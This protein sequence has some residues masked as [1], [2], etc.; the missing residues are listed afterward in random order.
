MTDKYLHIVCLDTPYPADYGGAIDIFYTLKWLSKLGIKIHLH[1]FEYGRGRQPELER[2]CQWVHYYPRKSGLK[3]ISLRLPYIVSSRAEPDLLNNLKKDK[4]PVLLEGIHTSYFLH[5]G[6]LTQRKVIL[7]LQNVE[8]KYYRELRRT[9]RSAINM[10]YYAAETMLLKRYEK[11]IAPM[12]QTLAVTRADAES[13]RALAS[14]VKTDCIP[15]FTPWDEVTGKEGLGSFCLY[16]G[17]LSVPEN[18]KAVEW[19]IREVFRKIDI[20]LVIAGKRPS[21]WIEKLTRGTKNACLVADPSESEMNDLV[22]KAQLHVLPSFNATGI[23]LKLLHALFRGRHC[24]VNTSMVAGTGL[25]TACQTADDPAKFRNAVTELFQKPFSGDEVVARK[26]LLM[27]QYSNEKN[28][29]K[30]ITLIW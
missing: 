4:N 3:G 5:S 30:L 18:E 1:C 10:L 19:L 12:A 25:E 14:G 8:W 29:R 15:V 24:L 20:P 21:S 2:Y 6:E 13:Y 17:N 28:V 26:Q 22:E 9:T 16:H 7:R 23:K 27:Q 11:E